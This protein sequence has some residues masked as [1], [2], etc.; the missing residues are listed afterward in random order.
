LLRDE[1]IDKNFEYFMEYK[2]F[3]NNDINIFKNEL[4]NKMDSLTEK[5]DFAS[6]SVKLSEA[7]F[8]FCKTTQ[9]KFSA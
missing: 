9:D 4:T 2:V 1:K 8:R 5:I 6:A 7:F 3:I